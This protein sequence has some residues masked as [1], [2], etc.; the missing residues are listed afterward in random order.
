M[1]VT[2]MPMDAAKSAGPKTMD[3]RRG[4]A[5]QI[6]STLIRPSAAAHLRQHDLVESFTGPA[7]DFDDVAVGPTGIPR[8]DANAQHALVPI[9]RANRIDDFCASSDFF[10]R[11]YGV[12]KVEKRKIR[13]RR[14]GLREKAVG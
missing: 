14:R 8:V 3:S 12:L 5:A 7:D 4:D 13:R 9:K 6:S 1:V 10:L 11:R 2:G